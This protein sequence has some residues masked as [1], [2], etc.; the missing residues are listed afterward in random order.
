MES[1]TIFSEDAKKLAHF[2]QGKVGLKSNLEAEV[3]ERGEEL[4][5]FEMAQGNGL[6]IM[7]HSKVKGK[8]SQ[9]DRIIFNLEV[10]DIEKE[11][12]KLEEAGVKKIKDVYHMQGYGLI[13][14]FEDVDGNYF[15]LV[16]VRP[17]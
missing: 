9:P 4:Y 5:G 12:K 16:Q 10:D 3:G 11:A 7:D 17:S 14:T 2:Y 13:A 6:Y 1:F 15:Q 8:S